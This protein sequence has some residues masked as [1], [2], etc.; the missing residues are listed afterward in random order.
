MRVPRRSWASV[1]C[2]GCAHCFIGDIRVSASRP[3]LGH[4]NFP[5]PRPKMEDVALDY[6]SLFFTVLKLGLALSP[7]IVLASLFF[8]NTDTEDAGQLK[9][10]ADF[11]F[12]PVE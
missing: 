6:L 8:F 5:L 9:G 12:D 10:K 2:F 11:S 4:G 7:I 1:A 3:S